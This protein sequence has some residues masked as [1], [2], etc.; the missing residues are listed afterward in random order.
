[1]IQINLKTCT[2]VLVS[3]L[4]LT[5]LTGMAGGSGKLQRN[6]DME[7]AF[8]EGRPP[9]DFVWYSTGRNRSPDA[10]VGL[11]PPWRQTARFWQEIDLESRDLNQLIRKVMRHNQIEPR[12]FDIVTSDGEVIGVYWS[13][14][15]W[16][17]VEIRGENEVQV[18]RPREPIRQ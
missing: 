9:A 6:M 13:T 16:T 8:N 14:L 15:F 4:L 12:A 10:I 7:Q 1:M 18:F 11:Q 2:A 5:S 3:L 17:R